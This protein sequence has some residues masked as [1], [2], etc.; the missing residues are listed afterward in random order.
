MPRSVS[1]AEIIPPGGRLIEVGCATGDLLASLHPAD[2]LGVDISPAMI[3][4]AA[5]KHPELRFRVHDLM[6]GPVGERADYVVAVD[7]AAPLRT[8][9][10]SPPPPHPA[11][12]KAASAR[13][14]LLCRPE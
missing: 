8:V 6:E 12:Q 13:A 4:R 3:E 1:L 5:R 2:G 9:D 11:S 7:V 14:T 10:E